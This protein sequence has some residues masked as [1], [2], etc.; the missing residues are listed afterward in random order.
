MG[1]MSELNTTNAILTKLHLVHMNRIDIEVYDPSELQ[2]L[3]IKPIK[4]AT[5]T[6]LCYPYYPSLDDPKYV[7]VGMFEDGE[8]IEILFKN[9]LPLNMFNYHAEISITKCPKRQYSVSKM[10][11]S[12]T[13]EFKPY[14]KQQFNNE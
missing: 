6:V 5:H 2:I 1:K 7:S 10:I 12:N 8:T 4:F 13:V 9:N 3:K 14:N 11:N